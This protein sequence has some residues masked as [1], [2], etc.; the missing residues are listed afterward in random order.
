[1]AMNQVIHVF[2]CFCCFVVILINDAA[3]ITIA[4]P[5]H[6]NIVQREKKQ[7]ARTQNLSTFLF[8]YAH[9]LAPSL[10]DIKT[11]IYYESLFFSSE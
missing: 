5:C 2:E 1:M 4:C 6:T 11:T 7:V 10:P 8:M 9:G 3:F